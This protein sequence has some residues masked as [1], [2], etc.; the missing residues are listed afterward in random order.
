[1][2]PA[3]A[4]AGGFPSSSFSS[5]AGGGKEE[6]KFPRGSSGSTQTSGGGGGC[7]PLRSRAGGSFWSSAL[8]LIAGER[9]RQRS[10]RAGPRLP[11]RRVGAVAQQK[12]RG[13]RSLRPAR[14]S[15][16]PLLRALVYG[17]SLRCSGCALPHPTSSP[18][19]ALPAPRAAHWLPPHPRAG[20]PPPLPLASLRG[21]PGPSSLHASSSSPSPSSAAQHTKPALLPIIRARAPAPRAR[22]GRG[23]ET[24]VATRSPAGTGPPGLALEHR[25]RDG[26]TSGW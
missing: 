5:R 1:M 15:P 19:P 11:S 12:V 17:W 22:C 9:R 26:C 18:P 6:K 10:L 2:A 8:L 21:C 7:A 3:A 16:A 23:S 14:L 13:V 4:V 20:Q 24:V 25:G